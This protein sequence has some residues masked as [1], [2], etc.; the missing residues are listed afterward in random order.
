MSESTEKNWGVLITDDSIFIRGLIKEIIIHKGIPLL[1][2]A[3]NGE[4][5]LQK[6]H[7]CLPSIIF[8]DIIMPKMNGIEVLRTIREGGD[9]DTIIIIVSTQGQAKVLAE[10]LTLG[11]N[12]FIVKPFHERQIIGTLER[13]LARERRR[14]PRIYIPNL[15]VYY[16]P[17]AETVWKTGDVANISQ[18]GIQLIAE[19]LLPVDLLIQVKLE[20]TVEG[21][22]ESSILEE[23]SKPLI[24]EGKVVW[25]RTQKGMIVNQGVQFLQVPAQDLEVL[26]NFIQ[27]HLKK[28]ESSQHAD[29]SDW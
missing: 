3:S 2:E 8:L 20:V 26:K 21:N 15:K 19:E 14:F 4:E 7:E 1:G 22:V 29:I 11:A 6:Y 28:F 10:A 9:K 12:D 5:C 18:D 24:L 25:A 17:E 27:G 13:C 23:D 16:K